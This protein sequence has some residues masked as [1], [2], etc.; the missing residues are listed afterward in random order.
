M[1]KRIIASVATLLSG[2]V[3]VLVLCLLICQMGTGPSLAAPA[4]AAPLVSDMAPSAATSDVGTAV[5]ISGTNF[6]AE[7][8]GTVTF[9]TTSSHIHSPNTSRMAA[10]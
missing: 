9:E 6:A 10:H 8:S 7:I 2:S 3:G 5:V 1:N 4:V